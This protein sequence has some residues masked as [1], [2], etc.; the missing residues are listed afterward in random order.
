M[1]RYG[2]H[3]VHRL[4]PYTNNFPIQEIHSPTSATPGIYLHTNPSEPSDQSGHP[5][6]VPRLPLPC[7]QE[8]TSSLDPST[9]LPV[10]AFVPI[11]TSNQGDGISPDTIEPVNDQIHSVIVGN[12]KHPLQDNDEIP[13]IPITKTRTNSKIRMVDT[14][15]KR[16]E[17]L[18]YD[19]VNEVPGDL[20]LTY[21]R[22][23]NKWREKPK[24][25][26]T[27]V[28]CKVFT[29]TFPSFLEPHLSSNVD[30]F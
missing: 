7:I 21:D 24:S 11:Q 6:V 3:F 1:S 9:Q 5:V 10:T 2:Q 29:S 23:R 26:F 4:R 17:I 13:P 15:K 18:Y 12:Q 25:Q 14:R 22:E 27:Q 30:M 16:L 28:D 19:N 8:Q 20:I